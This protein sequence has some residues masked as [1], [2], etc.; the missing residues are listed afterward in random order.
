MI[1]Q[2][3]TAGRELSHPNET[4]DCTVIALAHVLGCQYSEAHKALADVG[5]RPRKGITNYAIN[6]ALNRLLLHKR[7]SYVKYTEVKTTRPSFERGI[8]VQS[9]TGWKRPFYRRPRRQGTT[10]AQ[11]LRSLPKIGRFY[12]TST[13]HAFAY[14][15]GKLLDNLNNSKLR[16]L[17]ASCWE[18]KLPEAKPE[19]PISQA[20]IN[21]LWARLDRI[22]GKV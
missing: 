2:T 21:E 19:P 8:L 10:V 18:V 15:D 12:L 7:V 4:N 20:Q 17:M 1:T 6:E 13:S 16:A 11:F 22:E 9:A 14:V 3:S 5:R